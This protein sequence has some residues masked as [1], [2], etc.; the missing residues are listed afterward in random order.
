MP[1]ELFVELGPFKTSFWLS[2]CKQSLSSASTSPSTCPNSFCFDIR[3][4]AV[5]IIGTDTSNLA[6]LHE[7]ALLVVLLLVVGVVAGR[8]HAQVE[9]RV[10]SSG[11][12]YLPL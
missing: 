5:A 7:V 2:A 9:V 4:V 12:R 11:L 1:D 10:P 3:A 6:G 8:V